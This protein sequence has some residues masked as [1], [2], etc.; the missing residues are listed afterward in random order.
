MLLADP[1]AHDDC[2]LEHIYNSHKRKTRLA[3]K[4]GKLLD[5]GSHVHGA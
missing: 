3:S 4:I 2:C 1:L 5:N